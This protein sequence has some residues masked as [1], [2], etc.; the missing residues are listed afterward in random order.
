M[1]RTPRL[2]PQAAALLACALISFG[3][4]EPAHADPPGPLLDGRCDEYENLAAQAHPLRPGITLY[5]H[6]DHDHVW[7]CYTVPAG[8]FGTLD[9]RLQSPLQP[10]ALNLHV[11]AQLGD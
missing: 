1:P 5:L 10:A 6:Q 4:A 7:L 2:P 9:L 3:L 11:S 8:S